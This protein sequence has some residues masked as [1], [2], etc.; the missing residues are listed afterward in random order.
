MD[1]NIKIDLKTLILASASSSI[2]VNLG[3]FLSMWFGEGIVF[4]YQLNLPPPPPNVRGSIVSAIAN[5]IMA[6]IFFSYY[7]F[8][9]NRK[10]IKKI[11]RIFYIILG[12]FLL[13][14][15][16]STLSTWFRLSLFENPKIMPNVMIVDFY[17][18]GFLRDYILSI[19]VIMSWQLH[20]AQE[21]KKQVAIKNE[22]LVADNIR[23]RFESLKNQVNPHFL[24]NSLNTLQYLIPE[25]SHKAESFLQ[26]LSKV[27]RYTLQ[28]KESVSL[29]EEMNFV[30]S[31]CN[32]MQIRYGNDL[33]FDINV[34]KKY[35]DYLVMPLSIQILIENA[36]KHNVISSKRTLLISV[37]TDDRGPYVTVKNEIIPKI[38]HNYATNG[39]GLS[40]LSER[41]RLKW[42]KDIEITKTDNYFEVNLFLIKE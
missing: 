28:N 33:V 2:V 36:I 13:T 14:L 31:Y 5:F 27:M 16:L 22:I 6:V 18:N 39:I 9:Y 30:N 26:E 41:Y 23:A 40:N 7:K 32:L 25:D 38:E 37:F 35:F 12:T 17:R 4:Q 34:E 15:I 29:A 19:V 42:N 8:I 3:V 20:I 21:R 24:F 1:K 10:N 11:F